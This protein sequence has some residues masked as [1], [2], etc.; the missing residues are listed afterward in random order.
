MCRL[1]YIFLMLDH[2]SHQTLTL[3]QAMDA[4][5]WRAFNL[6]HIESEHRG[7]VGAFNTSISLGSVFERLL[8]WDGT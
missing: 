8:N 3:G 1:M 2:N 7:W 6:G 4:Q 5:M